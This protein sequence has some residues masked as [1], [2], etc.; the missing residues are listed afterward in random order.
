M[1]RIFFIF[2]TIAY[3]LIVSCNRNANLAVIPN[4]YP[5]YPGNLILW[6]KYN[7]LPTQPYD[8]AF[9]LNTTVNF[10]NLPFYIVKYVSIL[11]NLVDSYY[12]YS[13]SPTYY[14][15]ISNYDTNLYGINHTVLL[16]YFYEILDTRWALNQPYTNTQA[17]T[18]TDTNEHRTLGN[19]ST[20]TTTI[21]V[22][23]TFTT[24]NNNKVYNQ[25]YG[26]VLK[27]NLVPNDGSASSVYFADTVY[28]APNVGIIQFVSYL[29]PGG[30][31]PYY[32]NIYYVDTK[33]Y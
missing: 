33:K 14:E 18:Y 22:N 19:I 23:G 4:Y 11:S 29:R 8:S 27:V 17:G 32:T 28:F 31:N 7:A 20:T 24:P 10:N 26:T 9:V 5:V 1:S 2:I 12:V 21:M 6:Q 15:G 3:L 13:N 30:N 25:V 16:N